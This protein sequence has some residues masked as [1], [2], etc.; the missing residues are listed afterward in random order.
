VCAVLFSQHAKRM[1]R[2]VLS[3]TSPAVPYFDKIFVGGGGYCS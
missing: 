3:V 2:V 1:R